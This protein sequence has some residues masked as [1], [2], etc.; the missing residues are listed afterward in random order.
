MK[1]NRIIAVACLMV[2]ASVAQAQILTG[3]TNSSSSNQVSSGSNNAG[4]AQSIN[5]NSD[6]SGSSTLKTI[7]SIGGQG[8]YGSFSADSC[9]NSGG[10]GGSVVGFGMNVAVPINDAECSARRNVERTMQISA[11]I[12]TFDPQRADALVNAAISIM[13]QVND[14]AKAA[15]TY[16]G[17]C[18]TQFATK[19][20]DL[21][22]D[23]KIKVGGMTRSQIDD[24]YSTGG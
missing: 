19:S 17:L 14:T 21:Q 5:F 16:A 3:T 22:V 13:C 6:N 12:R 10:G 15:Y 8:F 4:N 9:V 11:S 24:L 20:S 18:P 2:M 1:I 7:P 23:P